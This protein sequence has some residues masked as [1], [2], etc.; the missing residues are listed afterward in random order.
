MMRLLMGFL[1]SLALFAL[2]SQDGRGD[3][4]GARAGDKGDWPKKV[5]GMGLTEKTAK[6]NALKQA[7]KEMVTCLRRHQPPLASW[8]PAEEFIENNLVDR[9]EKGENLP[10]PKVGMAM[11]WWLY[12]KE[13][14][15]DR[16]YDMDKKAQEA[17]R[18]E[19]GKERLIVLARIFAGVL[20]LLSAIAGCIRLDT[21]TRGTYRHWLQLAGASLVVASWAGLWLLI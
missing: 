9:E 14:D 5:V 12:L 3:P 19:R 21:L 4:A 16:F 7:Q 8:I 15:W 18:A 6:E 1:W 20:V 10:V 11:R 13:P 17:E 2:W